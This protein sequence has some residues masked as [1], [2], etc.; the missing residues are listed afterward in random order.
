MSDGNDYLLDEAAALVASAAASRVEMRLLGGLAV[1]SRSAS[2]RRAPW[3]RACTDC[4]FFA[5]AKQP[6]VEAVFAARGWKADAEFNLYN[7]DSR[8][9]FRAPEGDKKADVFLNAFRMCHDIPLAARLAA[10][11]L[12]LPLSDLLLTKLQVVQLNDKDFRDVACVLIDHEIGDH[13]GPTV[14][15]SAFASSCSA[16]W[17][18]WR[19]V[20]GNLE[21]FRAWLPSSGAA[22]EE[23]EAALARSLALS[24]ALAAAPKSLAWKARSVIG[25]RMPWYQ[26]PEEAER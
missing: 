18:L 1:R 6:A 2:S 13:D 25:D 22:S 5:R 9:S 23:H 3:A 8:L 19:T 14:N 7:G 16:D 4:D 15:R 17:G 12:T 10:D 11:E 24:E 20:S 26:L 21:R